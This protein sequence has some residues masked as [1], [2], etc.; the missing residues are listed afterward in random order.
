M[1]DDILLSEL[2]NNSMELWEQNKDQWSPMEPEY[3]KIFLL[4]MIGEIGE[5]VEIIKKKD[6][7]D[8]CENKTV[9]NK[10]IEELVDVLM[11]YIDTLNRFKIDKK[12]F[13]EIYKK[14][15]YK[16]LNRNYKDEYDS[17]FIENK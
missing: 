14:K 6:I 16:N 9:R 1:K 15:H 2:L 17:L 10:F 3:G 5:V 8:I 11:Y 7:K 4:Y 12:E 13:V